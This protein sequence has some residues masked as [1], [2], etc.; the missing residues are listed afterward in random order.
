ML[1]ITI[2]IMRSGLWKI[3]MVTKKSLKALDL[4][5]NIRAS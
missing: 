2:R 4:G 5:S 3:L 1:R